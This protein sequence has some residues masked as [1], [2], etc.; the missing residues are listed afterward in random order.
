ML[1]FEKFVA[2][3]GESWVQD[4][5]ERIERSEG[6]RYNMAIPLEERWAVLMQDNLQQQYAAA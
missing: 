1:E 5:V 4:I 6:I 3:H 2:R